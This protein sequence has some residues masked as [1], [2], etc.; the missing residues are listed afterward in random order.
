MSPTYSP[1]GDCP[2][3]SLKRFARSRVEGCHQRGDEATRCCL[4]NIYNVQL[5]YSPSAGLLKLGRFVTWVRYVSSSC[6]ILL[7]QVLHF[8]SGRIAAFIHCQ[9]PSKSPYICKGLFLEQLLC[10]NI[11]RERWRTEW[12]TPRLLPT[13]STKPSDHSR[14]RV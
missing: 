11:H 13:P 12:D 14:Y 5:A 10:T 1:T 8:Y 2:P 9:V 3:L 4:A 7:I 6:C